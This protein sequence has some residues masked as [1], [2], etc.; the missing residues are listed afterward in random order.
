M[1]LQ[2]KHFSILSWKSLTFK[3]LLI[4]LV[5]RWC[6]AKCYATKA[7]L[8]FQSNI[9]NGVQITIFSQDSQV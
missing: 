6:C 9:D 1:L 5:Q 2:F 7:P 4:R 8:P 3:E